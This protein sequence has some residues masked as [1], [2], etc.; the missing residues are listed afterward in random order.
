MGVQGAIERGEM[1][2]LLGSLCGLF[3][4]PF[5]AA[6]IAQNFPPPTTRV[7]LHEAARALGMQTG[8]HPVAGCDWSKV[9]LPA[10]AFLNPDDDAAGNTE[11]APAASFT[12]LPAKPDSN[13]DESAESGDSAATVVQLP[14]TPPLTPILLIKASADQLLYF[15]PGR[16]A[17]ETLAIA[18]V[19]ARLSPELIL[20]AKETAAGGE[21]DPIA[22]FVREKKA[23]GFSWFI[24]EL[25]KHQ[26]IW[27]DVTL[28]SLAMQVVGLVTPLFTQVIIDKVIV[29]QSNSTLIRVNLFYPAG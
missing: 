8:Q 13:A 27:R 12:V 22:G 1:L 9:P 15:R 5:D 25:K 28:A 16:Q 24:P 3:R 26:R 7:T 14:V 10:I 17:A 29:H 21:D 4:I 20:V 11:D 19:P 23:F 2:W 6:L 18:D